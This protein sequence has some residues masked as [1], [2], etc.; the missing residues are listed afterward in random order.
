MAEYLVEINARGARRKDRWPDVWFHLRRNLQRPQVRDHLLHGLEHSVIVRQSLRRRRVERLEA[1]QL[2]AVVG[3]AE[4][5]DREPVG[6]LRGL[7]GCAV[8][9]DKPARLAVRAQRSAHVVDISMP[10][11][12]RGVLANLVFP[13]LEIH[14]DRRSRRLAVSFGFGW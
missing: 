14:L 11:E 6:G 1:R 4:S 5:R 12:G 2:H 9:R 10:L 8:A 7:D 13:G 3:L